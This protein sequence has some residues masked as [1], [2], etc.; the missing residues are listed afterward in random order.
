VDSASG[1]ERDLLADWTV[2]DDGAHSAVRRGCGLSMNLVRFPLVLLGFSFDWPARLP[3]NMARIWLNP[4]RVQTGILGM[5]TI[6]LPEGRGAALV[7][8]WPE[9][10]QNEVRL[11]QGLCAFAAGDSLLEEL[12]G[13]RSYPGGFTHFRIGWGRAP[14]FGIPGALLIGDAGHPVTPAGGQ[15]A[16][17]SVADALVIAEA[18]LERPETLLEEYRRRRYPATMRSLSFSRGAFR[19][20]SLPRPV[21]N[22]GLL[23]LPWLARRLGARPE[24][25]A[26]VLRTVAGAFREERLADEATR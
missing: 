18:A 23:V 6:P 25:F 11:R 3:P 14:R 10:L 24:R 16:N 5:P 13:G 22:V 4:Q 17:L 1:V 9:L 19:I 8:V 15:G 26:G 20:F 12:L 21:L 7:P 2:G